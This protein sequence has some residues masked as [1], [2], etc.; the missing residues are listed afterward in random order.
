MYISNLQHFLNEQG[1]I[2]A[3]MPKKNREM[4]GFHAL[5]VDSATKDYPNPEKNL[6]SDVLRKNVV[7]SD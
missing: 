5:I 3:E 7:I 6:G 4:A 1:N 2:P